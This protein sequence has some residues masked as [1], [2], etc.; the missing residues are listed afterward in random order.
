[1]IGHRG[2]QAYNFDTNDITIVTSH[3]PLG[4]LGRGYP[5]ER[6]AGHNRRRTGEGNWVRQKF[7]DAFHGVLWGCQTHGDPIEVVYSND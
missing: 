4:A 2:Q 1:M 5:A 6:S 7:S 3:C